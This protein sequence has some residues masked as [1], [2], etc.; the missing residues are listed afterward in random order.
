MLYKVSA[1][2]FKIRMGNILG[3]MVNFFIKLKFELISL[4]VISANTVVIIFQCFP[5]I[6]ITFIIILG[7]KLCLPI[8][9]MKKTKYSYLVIKTYS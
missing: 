9:V 7:L 4:P 3:N 2:Y 1:Q 8:F 6:C 5:N